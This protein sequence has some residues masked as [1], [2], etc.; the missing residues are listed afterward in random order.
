MHAE[1]HLHFKTVM[2]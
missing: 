1:S 2:S